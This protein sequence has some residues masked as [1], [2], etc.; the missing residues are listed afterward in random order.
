MVKR[1]IIN[2]K[3]DNIRFCEQN[4]MSTSSPG[5]L[6]SFLTVRQRFNEEDAMA[7]ETL[8]LTTFI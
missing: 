3:I 1:G 8:L 5:R 6:E 4:E 2:F 7:L